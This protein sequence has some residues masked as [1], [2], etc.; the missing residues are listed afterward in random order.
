VRLLEADDNLN[1]MLLERCEPG[2]MLRVL[3]EP[4]QDLVIA[5]L[6][7][8][9]W[10]PPSPQFAFRPVSA[11]LAYWAEET[12]AAAPLWI[13]SGLVRAGLRLF[14]ELPR[15]SSDDVVLATDL[16]AG[17][18]LRAQ[19]EPWLAIDPKPFVGDRAYDAT[20][21]LCN[22]KERMRTAPGETILRFAD[23]LEIDDERIRM[24]M[25][26][27]ARRSHA[28]GGTTRQSHWRQ[29]W[30]EQ[31]IISRR[32]QPFADSACW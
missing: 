25:F 7:R 26:A 1:A 30:S 18:V 14:D 13:D 10:R 27:R 29:R 32:P 20:Q 24:W 2:D 3:P 28:R 21:H 23:L 11:M 19:R 6:L 12:I 8:R 31:A 5:S 17:N 15:R 4:E 9:L 22:C 16:H